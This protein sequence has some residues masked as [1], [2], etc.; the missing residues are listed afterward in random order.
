MKYFV[1]VLLL[2]LG[3]C[4]P[5]TLEQDD[6]L[7]LTGF[8]RSTENGI[9]T[10]ERKNENNQVLERG[11]LVSGV[12]QGAWISYHP[13]S[14]RIKSITTY[15]NGKKNGPY[16]EL[17]ERADVLLTQHYKNDLL[18]GRMAKYKNNRPTEVMH[19]KGGKLDGL[20]TS[21]FPYTNNPQRTA[22]FKDGKQ[23]GFLDYY[24]EDGKVT[25]RFEYK[26]GVK[27]GQ[28]KPNE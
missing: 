9:T 3:A 7:D 22:Q 8:T 17:N 15:V 26:N 20:Y 5:Q 21:Y 1:Y 13:N 19:Y 27:V 4:N 12:R 28:S 2:L 23:H 24:D 6:A 10:V 14:E 18:D 11:T 16:I 25:I